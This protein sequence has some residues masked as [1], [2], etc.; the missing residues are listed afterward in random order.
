MGCAPTAL[1]RSLVRFKMLGLMTLAAAAAYG[2]SKGTGAYPEPVANYLARL[3]APGAQPLAFRTDYPGGFQ[4]W[5]TE[6]RAALLARLGMDR[7]A[8][9]AAGHQPRVV[10]EKPMDRGDFIRQR[11]SIETEPGILI[12]FWLLTPKRPPPWP[13]GIFP[14]GHDTRGHDTTAGVFADEAHTGKSV[15]EDRDVAVQAVRHGFIAIAPATRG[16][17]THVIPDLDARHG[18]REC[19]SQVIHCLLAGRT[20]VGERVWD[21]QR[22]LDW[23]IALPNADASHVLMM[24]NSGGGMVTL[25][26]AACD[27]RITI[28]VPSCSFAPSAS[29][30]GYIFH[31]DCNTVPGLMDIGGLTGVAGLA[32]PRRMLAVNGRKDPLFTQGEIERGVA[33]ARMH[34]KAAGAPDRF[35]HAWGEEGHRFYADLMWPFVLAAIQPPSRR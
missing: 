4:R 24:G 2:A 35:Q 8:A 28:A 23:A 3:Y 12:P 13:V 33:E 32:A 30:S 5:R 27:E 31:C 1:G 25:F 9:A 29:A 17:S 6:A 14:H 7:I 16:I 34:F 18:D 19:R 15:A 20:A 21:V 26:A 10:L 22:I 11:G